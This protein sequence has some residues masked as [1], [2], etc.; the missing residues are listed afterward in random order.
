MINTSKLCK[1]ACIFFVVLL[2]AACS[3]TGMTPSNSDASSLSANEQP[4]ATSIVS[5]TASSFLNSP[6]PDAMSYPERKA[7]EEAEKL[8]RT[9][10]IKMDQIEN[11]GVEGDLLETVMTLLEAVKNNDEETK[12]KLHYDPSQLTFDAVVEPFIH[13]FTK[14]E[15]N[16]TDL[17]HMMD[18]YDFYSEAAIVHITSIKLNRQLQEYESIG[19]YIFVKIDGQWLMYRSY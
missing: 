2:I 3:N 18:G 5:S 1:N 4:P 7:A 17:E 15:L 8:K 9:G 13:A 6:S 14:I 11:E 16:N 19:Q 12:R 10:E